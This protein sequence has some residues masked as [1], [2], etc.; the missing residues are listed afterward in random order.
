MLQFYLDHHLHG[1]IELVAH[2]ITPDEMMNTV[3][4]LPL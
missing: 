2:C 4:F 3:L 1:A